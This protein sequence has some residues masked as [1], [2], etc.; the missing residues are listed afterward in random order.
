MGVNPPNADQP[1]LTAD[2]IDLLATYAV[3]AELPFEVLT[4]ESHLAAS[5]PAS[6]AEQALRFA[7][8]TYA[9]ALLV[10]DE[11]PPALRSQILDA[12]V[13]G[14]R[15]HQTLP[16]P[17]ATAFQLESER[18]L[19]TLRRMPHNLWERPVHPPEFGGWTVHDLAA[20]LTSSQSLFAQLLGVA[21]PLVPETDNSNDARTAVVIAR[22]RN[23]T[24]AETIAEYERATTAIA[25]SV[26]TRSF[27]E[28]E[29]EIVWWGVSMRIST[30]LLHR[31]FETWIHNDDLVRASGISAPP[32]SA[33]ALAAMSTRAAEWIGLFL[34]TADRHVDGATAIIDLTGP[35]GGH[36]EVSIGLEPPVVSAPSPG[37][38]EIRF[39]LTMD[40]VHFCQAIGRRT[41][42]GG[43]PFQATGDTDLAATL[44]DC[45]PALAGL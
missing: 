19:T 44:V 28:L 15:G 27:A 23:F 33:A 20:H 13:A 25:H 11:P 16:A 17:A 43:F 35:G 31:T 42:P 37:H 2:E 30:V 10:A 14:R 24:P 21:D 12:A 39:T 38:H 34:A 32:V 7:A 8:A 29:E 22:H 41:P 18:L 26:A 1:Q 45:L 40:V 36:H 9:D 6:Q 4:I 3:G 5:A